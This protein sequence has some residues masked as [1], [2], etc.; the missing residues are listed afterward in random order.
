MKQNSRLAID[1][2]VVK[3]SLEKLLNGYFGTFDFNDEF[4]AEA[5]ANYESME[6][7]EKTVAKIHERSSDQKENGVFYTPQDVCDYI[8]Y[9]SVHSLYSKDKD[10]LLD[11]ESLFKWFVQNNVASDFVPANSSVKSPI[12]AAIFLIE[13]NN[14]TI[15]IGF[16]TQQRTIIIFKSNRIF[17]IGCHDID[18]TT[19]CDEVCQFDIWCIGYT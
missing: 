14:I 3:N 11:C 19:C 1:Y 15:M 13:I 10:D 9:N 18:G 17:D 7:F 8:V 16:F 12:S 4:F 5:F 2:T 6:D